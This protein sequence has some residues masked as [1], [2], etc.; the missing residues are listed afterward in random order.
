MKR[1]EFVQ[2]LGLAEAAV[3]LP[4]PLKALAEGP[5]EEE[6]SYKLLLGDR[7]IRVA[8]IRIICHTID[9][10]YEH[11]ESP[12]SEKQRVSGLTRQEIHFELNQAPSKWSRS[13]LFDL[14]KPVDLEICTC[15]FSWKTKALIRSYTVR[16][17]GIV[18]VEMVGIG[19]PEELKGG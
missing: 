10:D 1:R 2:L 11:Y 17:D 8:E 16:E 12:L 15:D 14:D 6:L 19:P 7:E 4:A 9:Y 5:L 3:V 13:G 18:D